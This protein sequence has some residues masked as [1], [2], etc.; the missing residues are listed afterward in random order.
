M[1]RFSVSLVIK[2]EA[3]Q[4]IHETPL[5]IHST[6]VTKRIS[7]N[8]SPWGHGE[9]AV[10]RICKLTSEKFGISSESWRQSSPMIQKV[11]SSLWAQGNWKYVY[12]KSWS[13]MFR[14]AWFIVTKELVPHNAPPL[15]NT[16]TKYSKST[17][18]YYPTSVRRV[19]IHTSARLD[20]VSIKPCKKKPD[21]KAHVLFFP[22]Y[23]KSTKWKKSIKAK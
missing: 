22:F 14:A 21:T 7:S 5:H 19:P 2:M 4:N 23:M 18:Q 12:I 16:Q 20:L 8:K 13:C 10:L 17:I 9:D 1:E 6:A 15:M 3:N 11:Y